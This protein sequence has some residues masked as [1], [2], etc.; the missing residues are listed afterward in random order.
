M[1]TAVSPLSP[2][3][4]AAQNYFVSSTISGSGAAV[5]NDPDD[6]VVLCGTLS[7]DKRLYRGELCV[8]TCQTFVP[9]PPLPSLPLA[10][11]AG[12]GAAAG[13]ASAGA[14]A[15]ATAAVTATGSRA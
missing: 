12:V 7:S 6:L 10:R 1:A 13:A 5:P 11:D 3:S 9:P 2:T 14:G 4:A 15:G 8:F